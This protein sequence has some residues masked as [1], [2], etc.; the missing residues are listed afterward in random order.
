MCNEFS[1][2][3]ECEENIYSRVSIRAHFEPISKENQIDEEIKKFRNSFEIVD[4]KFEASDGELSLFWDDTLAKY[5]CKTPSSLRR[6]Q[7]MIEMAD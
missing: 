1:H 5:Q 3:D 2:C 4:H 7:I 6:C